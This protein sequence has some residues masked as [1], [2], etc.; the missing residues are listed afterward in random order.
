MK[1]LTL[2][3]PLMR[4]RDGKLITELSLPDFKADEVEV[5]PHYDGIQIIAIKNG[6]ET[7]EKRG[8]SIRSYW[9]YF[10]LPESARREAMSYSFKHGRLTITMPIDQDEDEDD[11]EDYNGDLPT[12]TKSE[13]PETTGYSDPDFP[14][15][16][17]WY[18]PFK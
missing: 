8:R 5:K 10:D 2:S 12:T 11:E 17:S 13:R 15:H 4:V 9:R 18:R 16:W 3:N 14:D 7:N 6:P 1:T